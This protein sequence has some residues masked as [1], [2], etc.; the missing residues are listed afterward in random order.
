MESMAKMDIAQIE[1]RLDKSEYEH[2]LTKTIICKGENARLIN[3]LKKDKIKLCFLG[4]SV[5]YGFMED[6]SQNKNCFPELT[7][8]AF[9]E[10]FPEKQ[11]ESVNLGISGTT[12]LT[13]IVLTEE[14]LAKENPDIIFVEYAIN[15]SLTP[16]GAAEYEG[17]VRKLVK[18]KCEPFVVPVAV[19]N[20]DKYS[21]QNY[22]QEISI[23][24]GLYM[25]GI[26]NALFDEIESNKMSWTDYSF[27]EGH[28]TDS[29]HKLICDC[30]V[31]LIKA[32]MTDKIAPTMTKVE[33]LI[34]D[35]YENIKLIDLKELSENK[36][37]CTDFSY[38]DKSN[39]SLVGCLERKEKK[40]KCLDVTLSCRF[41]ALCYIQNK[42]M[43][44]CDCTVKC[45]DKKIAVL[46]GSSIFGW[47]NPD[48]KI[49]LDDDETQEHHVT[50][51]CNEAGSFELCAIMIT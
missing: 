42:Y 48:I 44:F 29:G 31:A 14:R 18:M 46:N 28:P 51:N 22:M 2:L 49:I 11:I 43:N 12:A 6:Y 26:A 4:A 34:S 39:F 23:H 8:K 30:I 9:K 5:T 32:A 21:C 15:Q 35:K 20:K 3:N 13:G 1:K 16:E 19:V 37:S 41:F 36:I 45:D 24:Y 27:D 17:L 47:G 10:M 40:T 33:A 25:I 7:C 38:S 50:V